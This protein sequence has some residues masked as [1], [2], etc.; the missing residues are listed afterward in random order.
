[1]TLIRKAKG[2]L[3]D[4]K[5]C[6]VP[7]CWALQPAEPDE[8]DLPRLAADKRAKADQYAAVVERLRSEADDLEAQHAK[9]VLRP[10]LCEGHRLHVYDSDLAQRWLG[11]FLSPTG[12]EGRRLL[13][14]TLSDIKAHPDV[15]R[16]TVSAGVF[17]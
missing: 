2:F 10:W 3:H 11:G 1:M 8:I 17:Q 9:I 14:S 16:G 7:E 15:P 5:T 12:A 4:D 13:S 6:V